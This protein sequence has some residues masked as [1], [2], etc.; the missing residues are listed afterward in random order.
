MSSSRFRPEID[1]LR[2]IAVLAVLA[3]HA[4]LGLPGGFVGVDVFFVLSGFL[5]TGLIL[6]DLDDGTFSFAEFWERRVRRI[7]PPLLCMLVGVL[8]IGYV[9]FLPLDLT[10]LGKAT[11]AQMA[12]AANV[13]AW[14]DT[15][16]FAQGSKLRPLLHMWSL[17]VEEQFYLVMPVVMA[18]TAKWSRK[19][20]YAC[21]ALVATAS[22]VTCVVGTAWRP[23]AAFFLLPTRMWELLV[24]GCL[25]FHRNRGT[26]AAAGEW[27]SGLGLAG[28][29]T[30][31]LVLRED[32]GFP[33]PAALAPTVAT[34]MVILGNQP[35]RSLVG[36]WLSAR[37]LVWVGSISY[38]LYLWHWPLLSFAHYICDNEAPRLVRLLALAVTFVLA[39]ASLA[40][41]ENPVRRRRVLVSRRSLFGSAALACFA[42]AA[43]GAVLWGTDG[44]PWR[45]PEVVALHQVPSHEGLIGAAHSESPMVP[46]RGPVYAI[47]GD[48]HASRL[49]ELFD[50]LGRRHGVAGWS[51]MRIGGPPILGARTEWNTDLPARNEHVA[52]DIER[53]GIRHVFLACRWS[54][55]VEG[56]P[57]WRDGGGDTPLLYV[58]D[59][60]SRTRDSAFVLFRDGLELLCNRLTS[61]GCRVYLIVQPPDLDVDPVRSA[62]ISKRTYGVVPGLVPEVS[63]ADYRTRQAR[64]N[65]V[66]DMLKGDR[67]TV[68][69]GSERFFGPDGKGRAEIDGKLLYTDSHHL[70]IVGCEVLVG[71]S[72]DGIF[73][74]IAA[75]SP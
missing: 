57:R 32:R 53:L 4:D 72:L 65:E 45:A 19:R 2:A 40:L 31:M 17:A 61:A 44:A 67:V 25:A 56:F 16:Y 69:D 59:R 28:I 29:V 37:P 64:V 63:L 55:Y 15:G 46:G 68:L 5:I 26:G 20:I 60:E 43:I 8:A 50:D 73:A 10:E 1:G 47:W 62:F 66:F 22:F 38:A 7:L 75:E 21:L 34:A 9:V 18:S 24:G 27:L 71:R 6:D 11:C 51:F 33:G 12:M 23:V 42:V 70:G 49:T 14:K 36:R 30:S 52:R 13:Y 39:I 58:K 54:S 74:E 48:S 41:V 3:F 35:A